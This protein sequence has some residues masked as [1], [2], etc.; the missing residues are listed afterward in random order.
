MLL[1]TQFDNEAALGLY[2]AEGFVILPERLAVLR[3][4]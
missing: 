3:S 1:N 2:E 4:Q